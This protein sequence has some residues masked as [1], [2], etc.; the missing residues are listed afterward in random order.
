[1]LIVGKSAVPPAL[2]MTDVVQNSQFPN[3]RR[4][5]SSDEEH[6]VPS[7]P[8]PPWPLGP[9]ARMKPKKGF[10]NRRL[11]LTLLF[12]RP[13]KRPKTRNDDA[14]ATDYDDDHDHDL[15]DSKLTFAKHPTEMREVPPGEA[16]LLRYC[17]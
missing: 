8:A 7:P 12:G 14:D 16:G 6:Q 3:K 2:Q 15:V 10:E 1:M 9:L 13:G 11:N 17:L 4:R 5:F